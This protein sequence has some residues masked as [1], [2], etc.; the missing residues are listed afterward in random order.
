MECQQIHFHMQ[1]IKR[2][3]GRNAV[4]CA[5]YRHALAMYDKRTGVKFDFSKS[6]K[7]H[8][9]FSK[10]LA[11]VGTP[12]PLLKSESLWQSVEFAE[13]RKDAQLC[14]EFD[15]GLPIELTKQ[16][17][18]ALMLDYCQTSFV[19]EGMIC[20]MEM[21]DKKDNPHFH[22]MITMRDIDPEAEHG[23]GKKNRKWN[24]K[25]LVDI[26]RHNYEECINRH[27]ALA[28]IDRKYSCE[29]LETQGIDRLPQ[30]HVGPEAV[31]IDERSEGTSWRVEANNNIIDFNEASSKLKALKAE[32]AKANAEKEE[33]VKDKAAQA[34]ASEME[35]QR[36][37]SIQ[38]YIQLF[39]QLDQKLDKHSL[40]IDMKTDACA[41]PEAES[42]WKHVGS[43]LRE[44][45]R[46]I[47]QSIR[48]AVVEYLDDY[49][50]DLKID[51]F[52]DGG[53]DEPSAAGGGDELDDDIEINGP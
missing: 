8:I 23:F 30:I 14:R 39:E 40:W 20:D 51:A 12:L 6:N 4:A 50:R 10:V 44:S 21:H 24:R 42:H 28:G 41:F 33:K 37:R 5:S 47:V 29:T 25:D 7:E 35:A 45:I 48:T 11:P 34:E 1:I 27:L 43:V 13:K 46:K 2:S 22:T 16:Q 3:E 52:G 32:V 36:H 49:G 17:Q 53:S 18:I 26:W 38:K 31:A 9:G 19:D 15:A